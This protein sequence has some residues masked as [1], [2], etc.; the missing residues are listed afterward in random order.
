MCRGYWSTGE[1]ERRGNP[2]PVAVACETWEREYTP[3]TLLYTGPDYKYKL[4]QLYIQE[5]RTI[6]TL[7]YHGRANKATSHVRPDWESTVHPQLGF[8]FKYNYKLEDI[9]CKTILM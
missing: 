1:N 6:L 7:Q 5:D 2:G 8:D 9:T 4:T 3:A